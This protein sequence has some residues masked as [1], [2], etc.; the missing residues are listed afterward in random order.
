TRS[1][2]IRLYAAAGLGLLAVSGDSSARRD[3]IVRRTRRHRAARSLAHSLGSFW[4]TGFSPGEVRRGAPKH[5]GLR[6]Q[7]FVDEASCKNPLI[8]WQAAANYLRPI[9]PFFMRA[10]RNVHYG[11]HVPAATA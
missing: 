4:G 9:T 5:A 10:P 2:R 1:L 3:N 8:P 7:N 11:V 6:K